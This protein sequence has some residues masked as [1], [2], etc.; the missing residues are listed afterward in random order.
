M[1]VMAFILSNALAFEVQSKEQD[2]FLGILFF[3]LSER[4]QHRLAD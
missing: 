2:D 4:L 1:G 3:R